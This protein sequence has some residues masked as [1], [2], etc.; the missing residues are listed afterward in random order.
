MNPKHF[1]LSGVVFTMLTPFAL[2][3]GGV[4]TRVDNEKNE[5]IVEIRGPAG[6]TLSVIVGK[7]TQVSIGK[8]A[9]AANLPAPRQGVQVRVDLPC[10]P[11]GNGTSIVNVQVNPTT[12]G[13][14]P[15]PG[16]QNTNPAPPPKGDPAEVLPVPTPTDGV[17][18]VTGTLRRIGL[19]DREI[20]VANLGRNGQEKYTTI[21]VPEKA[22]IARNGKT[23]KLE[24]L[25]DEEGVTVRMETRD[26]K[27]TAVSIQ[28]GSAPLPSQ[29]QSAAPRPNDTKG[30][31]L[32]RVRQVL[33]S[34]NGTMP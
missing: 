15:A 9:G 17:S 16:A 2:G 21:T 30:P 26:G 22:L 12:N 1:F 34:L 18:S 25:K 6:R 32:P 24:E 8:P 31:T 23:I 14:K 5:V 20:T 27:N 4:I 29:P 33:K 11:C 7:T 10:G 19:T 3:Q 28:A 13:S